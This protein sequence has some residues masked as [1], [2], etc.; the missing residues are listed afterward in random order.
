MSMKAIYSRLLRVLR[1]FGAARGGNIAITFA[2][3]TLPI[4]GFVGAAVDFSHANS[5]KAAMVAALDS[6]ALMLS[7]EAA[8]DTSTQLQTNAQQY[9]SALFTRP[10]ATNVTITPSYTTSGGSQVV[11]NGSALVPTAF[12]GIFGYNN[13]TVGSSSTVKWGNSRLRVALVLDNT[14]S[15]GDNGKITA[16]KTATNNLLTQLQSATS[17]NGDVYVS[18]IPFAKD[19]NLGSTNYTASWIDWTDWNANNGTCNNYS[20]WSQPQ[21]QSDCSAAHGTW[22]ADNHNTWNGCV[23]DR[24]NSGSPSTGNYDENVTAPVTG[25]KATMFPAEQYNACP[26][27]VMGL[28]YNWSSMTTVVNN[29]QPNGATNQPIGLV[30]GWQTLVG[31]GPFT[32]PAMDPNYT[33]TQVIILLSDGLNTQDRWYGNG[34]SLGT[35]DDQKIDYRMYDGSGNGTCANIKAAGITIYTIQVNTSGDPT[36]LLL[37]NCTS[38]SDKFF[39]LTSATEIVTT[40]D[41]IGTKLSKLYVAK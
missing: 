26:Q 29:M 40:F 13:I 34:S 9:F 16:L 31:G 30:W 38:S 6:T 21:T 39:L 5:V 36:S 20:G 8:K 37:Q 28:S 24:G 7:K 12:M 32:A 35:T 4:I 19:V 15:M 17:T 2:L 23:T 25:T 10:E 18:I 11:V 27:A 22:T 14:G 33:Y 3:A 41:T 1:N